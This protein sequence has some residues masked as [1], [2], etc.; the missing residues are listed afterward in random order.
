MYERKEECENTEG[1]NRAVSS[2]LAFKLAKISAHCKKLTVVLIKT[3][4]KG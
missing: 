1:L 2:S 3:V 4:R